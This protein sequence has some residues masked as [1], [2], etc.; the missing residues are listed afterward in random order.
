MK[1]FLAVA[2]I[3]AWLFGTAL[4]LAPDQFYAPAGIAFTPL[5]STIAQAHGAALVGLGVIDWLGRNAERQGLI[6]VLAGNLVVQILSLII[7]LRTLSL[8]AGAAV[9]PGV[10]IHVVLGGF[11]AYFLFRVSHIPAHP[12]G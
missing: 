7:V 4:L 9:T 6:A 3:V 5:L 1:V 10:I 11:F 8:G 12:R 2:A